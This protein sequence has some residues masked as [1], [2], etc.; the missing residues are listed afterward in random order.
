MDKIWAES[1]PQTTRERQTFLRRAG[2]SVWAL[3]A[4]VGRALLYTVT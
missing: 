3:P 2:V 4:V 1:L